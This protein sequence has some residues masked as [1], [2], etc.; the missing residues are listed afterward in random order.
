MALAKSSVAVL[1]FFGG[2]ADTLGRTHSEMLAYSNDRL[3]ECHD[4]V[5]VR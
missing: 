2:G 3:E 5:Q 4:W 1:R